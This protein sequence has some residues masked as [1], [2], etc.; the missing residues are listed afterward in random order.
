MQPWSRAKKIGLCLVLGLGL[1]IWWSN[2]FQHDSRMLYTLAG[3]FVL[4]GIGILMAGSHEDFP[5]GT[6]LATIWM[7]TFFLVISGCPRRHSDSREMQKRYDSEDEAFVGGSADDSADDTAWA[8]LALLLGGI[9]CS[10]SSRDRAARLWAEYK[11]ALSEAEREWEE[12]LREEREL[13]ECAERRQ[14][15]QEEEKRRPPDTPAE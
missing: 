4:G 6:K 12:E 10:E 11:Q 14:R 8:V 9:V 3:G 2:D 13:R 1:L 7:L 15:Q 5:T